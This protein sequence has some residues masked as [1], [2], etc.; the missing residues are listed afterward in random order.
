MGI[1][2][3]TG[4]MKCQNTGVLEYWSNEF[5]PLSPRCYLLLLPTNMASTLKYFLL[6]KMRNWIQGHFTQPRRTELS[7][8]SRPRD[9]LLFLFHFFH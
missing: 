1:Y 5:Y 6:H 3:K 4:V 8:K 2:E 7:T 9:R